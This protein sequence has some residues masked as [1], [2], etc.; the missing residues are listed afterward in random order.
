MSAVLED[1]REGVARNWA[2]NHT[3]PF[4]GGAWPHIDIGTAT[5]GKPRSSIQMI[6][7]RLGE[8]QVAFRV[9]PRKGWRDVENSYEIVKLPGVSIK[10]FIVESFDGVECAEWLRTSLGLSMTELAALASVTRKA[11]YDWFSGSIPRPEI[12]QKLAGMRYVFGDTDPRL[13]RFVPRTWV[14]MDFG[15]KFYVDLKSV[16]KPKSEIAE[17]IRDDFLNMIPQLTIMLE[18]SQSKV[19]R[20]EFGASHLEDIIRG[21]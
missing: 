1:I 7:S 13:L 18:R 10:N 4:G 14:S 17:K 5:S 6:V 21:N 3:S 15:K 9:H 8:G 11:A 20:H 2:D 12:S 19:K 16:D